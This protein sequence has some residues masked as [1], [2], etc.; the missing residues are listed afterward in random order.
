M[1][2]CLKTLKKTLIFGY[3]GPMLPI[4]GKRNFL[5][6]QDCV[7]FQILQFTIIT[8]MQKDQNNLMKGYQEGS[9]EQ[10]TVISQDPPFTAI[11]KIL[12]LFM[13]HQNN[14]VLYKIY[15]FLIKNKKMER[16]K[17]MCYQYLLLFRRSRPEVVCKKG[18]LNNFAKFTG[19]HLCQR[20]FFNKVTLAQVFSSEFGEITKKTFSYRTPMVP[21][22]Y[23]SILW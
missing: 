23:P 12:K 7:R 13:I 5:G 22:S 11:Q 9:D 15:T 2:K 18:V 6:K 1:T 14:E 10:T 20:N 4:L 19:K 21:A 16:L 3:F 17:F 8:I